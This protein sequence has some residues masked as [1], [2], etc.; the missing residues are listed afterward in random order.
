MPSHQVKQRTK[1]VLKK[2]FPP[3]CFGFLFFFLQGRGGHIACIARKC[4]DATQQAMP[5]CD[6]AT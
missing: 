3:L 1:K 5:Q 2:N 4:G 6:N